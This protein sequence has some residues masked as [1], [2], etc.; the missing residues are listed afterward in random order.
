MTKARRPIM[1][2]PQSAAPPCRRHCSR[3]RA[4]R[5][6]CPSPHDAAPVWASVRLHHCPMGIRHAHVPSVGCSTSLIMWLAMTWDANDV[7]YVATRAQRMSARAGL[8]PFVRL[9]SPEH[10][11]EY[12]DHGSRFARAAAS[13]KARVLEQCGR[14]SSRTDSPNAAAC[15]RDHDPASA[16]QTP[17]SRGVRFRA[18]ERWQ[19]AVAKY[20]VER[21]LLRPVPSSRGSP[22]TAATGRA[23]TLRQFAS[24][25]CMQ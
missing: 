19:L 8:Q 18:P 4:A 10:V 16:V 24:M 20:P 2:R 14:P 3:R 23:R 1:N 5:S 11:C 21:R 9:A 13:L 17:G 22:P 6:R 7:S 12:F 15:S 25:P